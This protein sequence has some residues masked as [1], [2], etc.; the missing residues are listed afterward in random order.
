[1]IATRGV[2]VVALTV[3]CAAGVVAGP[4]LADDAQIGRTHAGR[5]GR[6]AAKN[7]CRAAVVEFNKAY[8][9]LK[10]PTLLFN[11]AECYRK[12]GKDAEALKDYQQFLVD[13]PAAPNR[14][15]VEGRIAL[16]KA[17][18]G[19]EAAGAPASPAA[20]PSTAPASPAAPSVAPTASPA[21]PA[22]P[23]AAR[24]AAPAT[25]AP[26]SP[27]PA[28]AA[29]PQPAAGSTP[30]SAATAKP[31]PSEKPPEGKQPVRRAEKWTD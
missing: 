20:S 9:L 13:M 29:R 23:P 28:A 16:L 12:L 6:L 17:E 31:G 2:A 24:T 1:M 11:R 14:K 27:A 5:A 7:K 30:A 10:D 19:L 25:H 21:P 26:T 15:D 18:V 22:A 3:F 8:K 4:T